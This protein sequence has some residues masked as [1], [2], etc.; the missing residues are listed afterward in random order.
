MDQD[1]FNKKNMLNI[2]FTIIITI[3]FIILVGEYCSK[4]IYFNTNVAVAEEAT[5]DEH[6]NK[7]MGFGGKIY[8]NTI[9]PIRI[10]G[11]TSIGERGMKY[12]TTVMTEWGF[13]EIKQED[14]SKYDEL[15]GRIVS[16]FT[17]HDLAIFFEFT[18]SKVIN[19]SAFIL[20]Y[21]IFG[22]EVKNIIIKQ[23]LDHNIN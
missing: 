19:P 2:V 12:Y 8:N 13:S 22:I 20:N 21:S 17:S 18:D 15:E 14:F 23:F 7:I 9:F 6:K 10:K 4:N 3:L 11:I 5:F 1:K 16:P